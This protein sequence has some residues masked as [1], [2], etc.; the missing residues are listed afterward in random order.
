[1]PLADIRGSVGDRR[2]SHRWLWPIDDAFC[3]YRPR[4]SR[5]L[6]GETDDRDIEVDAGEQATQP[7]ADGIVSSS[8]MWQGGAGP[9]DEKLT[10]IAVATLDD[11]EEFNCRSMYLI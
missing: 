1:M 9:V 6:V 10:Q 4:Y 7:T 5:Q 8:E 3:E 2:S 11:G